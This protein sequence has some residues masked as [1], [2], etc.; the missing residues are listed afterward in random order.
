MSI[1]NDESRYFL[2]PTQFGHYLLSCLPCRRLL[3][4]PASPR[5]MS[6]F[7]RCAPCFDDFA[8]R[9]YLGDELGR[10]AVDAAAV[11]AAGTFDC[12]C[13]P[14]RLAVFLCK[15]VARARAVNVSLRTLFHLLLWRYRN[16]TARHI[17][18]GLD[19]WRTGSLGQGRRRCHGLGM[20]MLNIYSLT[21]PHLADCH[22]IQH[23]GMTGT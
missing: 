9:S 18:V 1:C 10:A 3:K 19:G 20:A 5:L 12:T 23:H 8:R 6:W 13:P 22:V 21:T 17:Q 2:F 11:L 15:N 4:A 14:N 7:R 16:R